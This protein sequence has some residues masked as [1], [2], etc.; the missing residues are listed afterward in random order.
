MKLNI[1]YFCSRCVRSWGTRSQPNVV[2]YAWILAMF[3]ILAMLE[4]IRMGL[5]LIPPFG[6]TLTVLMDLPEAPVAQPYAVIA[7]SVIGASVGTLLSLFSHG[8]LMAIVAAV[9]AFCIINLIHAY[10]PPGVALAMYPLLL[11]PGRW[12]PLTVVLPFTVVAIGSA[13]LL[14]RFAPGWPSY[15]KPLSSHQKTGSIAP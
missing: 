14:S 9:T 12:F 5:F 2:K 13:T 4:D 6:A 15:P 11:Y 7:G 10:H 1:R 8:A 3:G